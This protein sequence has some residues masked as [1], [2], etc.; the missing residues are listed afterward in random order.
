M[1]LTFI[2]ADHEVTGSAHFL[3]ACGK[4]ILIDYG[5][6]QGINVFEN[7]S[8]P[9][10]ISDIDYVLVTHAHIDHIGMIPSLYIKGFRSKIIATKPTCELAGIML[11]DSAHIQEFEAEWR[12]RKAKRAGKPEYIPLYTTDDVTGTLK[13]FTS[14]PYGEKLKLCDGIDMRF[15]D[16]GHLLGSASIELFIDEAGVRK[17]ICFSGDIGNYN[18]PLIKDPA[19][20]TSADYVVMESTYGDRLHDQSDDFVKTLTDII[21]KTFDA[22]GNVV[23]PSFAVGRTQEILYFIRKIKEDKLVHGHDGFEV[24]IDSPLGIEA[25]QIFNKNMYECFDHEAMELVNK[26][27]NPIAFEG[28]KTAVTSSES[29]A[30]NNDKKPKVIISASGMCDAGRIRHHLKH[31]LWRP[32]CSVVFV[33]YQAHATLGRALIEGADEVRIFGED[34][35]VAAH[36]YKL[37]GLSGH[38]DKNGLLTWINAF[39]PKPQNVFIVHGEDL[40]CQ[41]FVNSLKEQGFK[42]KAPYSGSI[43][44]LAGGEW[45]YEAE[46]VPVKKDDK[47]KKARTNAVFDRLV[48]AGERLMTVI[49]HNKGGANKDLAKF[50]DQINSLCDR[51]DR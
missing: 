1:R 12:N 20:T 49:N 44:D 43:F 45:V 16:V 5:M 9:V 21:Q 31:N 26:G 14:V 40:T 18:Q 48:A 24:V 3:Q 25:T 7:A 11:M 17:T 23:I 39:S 8:L 33:G 37:S 2:G 27:I 28:L 42:A 30:I 6:E 34:I 50:A 22:G 47:D 4:N 32:E 35:K 10:S 46:P 51:F 38:A 13:L 15:T 36:I 41:N 19:Y 29:V